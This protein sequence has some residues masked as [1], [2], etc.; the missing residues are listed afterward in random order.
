MTLHT[1]SVPSPVGELRLV[2]S[3]VGLR[4]VLWPDEDDDRVSFD[5]DLVPHDHPI[6]DAAAQQLGEYFAGERTEFDLPL[7]PHGTEFQVA[8]WKALAE[9][10]YGETATYGEQ[11]E[12]IGRP[13]AVRAV[14]AANGRNPLS[15]VLPCHRVVGADG[16]LTGFAG[17]LDAKRTLLDLER[18]VARL[19]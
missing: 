7:D 19:I 10:P 2:A 15:I 1:R 18:G 17:G 11:A 9:I 3:D 5:D 12:R 4:A 16:S 8:A 13:T 14:G 6:L